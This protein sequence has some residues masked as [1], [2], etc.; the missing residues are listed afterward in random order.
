MNYPFDMKPDERASEQS[1]VRSLATGTDV[2]R[3]QVNP[4][5]PRKIYLRAASLPMVLKPVTDRVVM[6]KS[7]CRALRGG[8]GRRA[9]KKQPRNLGDPTE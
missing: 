9:S 6:G 1:G 3:K 5:R 7:T 2:S 4:F 8:R